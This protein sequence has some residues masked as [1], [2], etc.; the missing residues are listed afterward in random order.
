MCGEIKSQQI[1]LVQMFT[2]TNM[3]SDSH[4]ALLS[5]RQTEVVLSSCLTNV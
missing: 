1:Q 4:V 2:Q 3:W 5:T